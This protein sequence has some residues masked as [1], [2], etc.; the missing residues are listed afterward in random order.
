L[1]M[2]CVSA[3]K[4]PLEDMQHGQ[5]KAAAKLHCLQLPLWPPSAKL[6]QDFCDF[7]A[8]C[9]SRLPCNRPSAGQVHSDIAFLSNNE[10]IQE[11]REDLQQK[12][13]VPEILHCW[14][15][16][17]PGFPIVAGS[18]YLIGYCEQAPNAAALLLDW[19]P[20][21]KEF[22]SWV[23]LFAQSSITLSALPLVLRPKS[24][25][26]SGKEIRAQCILQATTQSM[27]ESHECERVL[28]AEHKL[29]ESQLVHVTFHHVQVKMLPQTSC[30]SK[31][32]L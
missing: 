30:T 26:D 11:G 1:L 5:I 29:A 2:Y 7:A 25:C 21:P 4:E 31:L 12:H 18:P 14:I 10:A 8:R 20:N 32:A 23:K 6:G 24:L 27:L 3:A 15:N 28:A 17:V 9:C 22:Q 16:N 19:V 13:M